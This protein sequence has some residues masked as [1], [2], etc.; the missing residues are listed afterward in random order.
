MHKAKNTGK[1]KQGMVQ[2]L[3]AFTGILFLSL[4][5]VS[6]PPPPVDYFELP[7]RRESW[8]Y[9]A[10]YGSDSNS[11]LSE[12]APFKTLSRAAIA[13][14]EDM[15]KTGV[16]VLDMLTVSS[17]NLGSPQAAFLLDGNTVNRTIT[18]AGKPEAGL[19]GAAVNPQHLLTLTN[20]CGI[21][22]RD[23]TLTGSTDGAGLFLEGES[24]VVM[25]SGRIT[26]NQHGAVVLGGSDFLMQ[27]GII[28]RNTFVYTGSVPPYQATGVYVSGAASSFTMTGDALITRN[29]TGLSSGGV[30]LED[31]ASCLMGG[32]ARITH[33]TGDA[34]NVYVG[35]NCSFSMT[36]NSV[37]EFTGNSNISVELDTNA[38][39]SMDGNS[40]VSDNQGGDGISGGPGSV[41][42]MSG[43]SRVCRNMVGINGRGS[44]ILDG[45]ASITGNGDNGIYGSSGEILI[46]G[47]ASVSHNRGRAGIEAVS[48]GTI[49][50]SGNARVTDNDCIGI[51]LGPEGSLMM[52]D[53][54]LVSGN[55]NMGIR[56][57]SSAIFEN[58]ISG[59][60]RIE[61]NTSQ[62]G[63]GGIYLWR[64]GTTLVIK[65]NVSISNNTSGAGNNV[66]GY[67]TG[68]GGGIYSSECRV[69]MRGG[70]I[71]GNRALGSMGWGGG[72]ALD[73]GAVF[74]LE[75][76]T[77]QNNTA[78][79]WGGGVAVLPSSGSN[80]NPDACFFMEGGT[81]SGNTAR[82]G[83]GV[84]LVDPDDAPNCSDGASIRQAVFALRGGTISGNTSSVKGG[85]VAVGSS[86]RHIFTKSGSDSVIYGSSAGPDSNV[87]VTGAAIWIKQSSGDNIGGGDKNLNG[88]FPGGSSLSLPYSSW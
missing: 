9:V 63:G 79:D 4:F 39:F 5:F 65:D 41:V 14:A 58:T 62:E 23:I 45:H 72:V 73:E 32:R 11:G 40:R 60:A 86:Y 69:I 80:N 31:G 84:A 87:S 47:N 34:G 12:A 13:A 75:S 35:S 49:T 85:G 52:G 46:T 27:G 53:D 82:S 43:Y 25:E 59:N 54:T 64:T 51:E 24:S 67:Q 61:N 28:E 8:Y 7:M 74:T 77:I 81:I 42:K 50:L 3:L 44:R 30:M 33:N 15:E 83:G 66:Y 6:C 71:S 36:E 76:G 17:E 68:L 20:G 56:I 55:T 57:W 19:L 22:L 26:E 2:G 1:N 21:A 38:M 37:I 78:E 18:I 70:T 10:S 29:G 16:F 48:N 88:D